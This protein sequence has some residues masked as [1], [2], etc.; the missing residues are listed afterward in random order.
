MLVVQLMFVC[1]IS[2]SPPPVVG[3]FGAM[4]VDCYNHTH[5][6]IWIAGTWKRNGICVG[7]DIAEMFKYISINKYIS[8]GRYM[9]C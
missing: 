7:P 3:T 6:V 1:V 2:T 4:S 8:D 9:L 5:V